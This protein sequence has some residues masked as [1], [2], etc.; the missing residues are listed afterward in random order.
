[1][2]R[3]TVPFIQDIVASRRLGQATPKVIKEEN[4]WKY[5]M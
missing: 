1:M 2:S 3:K 4:T 5:E